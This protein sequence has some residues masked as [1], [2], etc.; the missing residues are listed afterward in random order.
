MKTPVS[1]G[2]LVK[3]YG[4]VL[5]SFGGGLKG[6]GVPQINIPTG[7]SR[8]LVFLVPVAALCSRLIQISRIFIF[9]VPG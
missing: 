5:T 8:V 1:I 6:T 7:V 3:R 2:F 4:P 9:I